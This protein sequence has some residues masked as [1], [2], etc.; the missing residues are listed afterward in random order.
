M[1]KAK[2]SRK[3]SLADAS[4]LCAKTDHSGWSGPLYRDDSSVIVSAEE[5]YA[6]LGP[7][8]P[9]RSAGRCEPCFP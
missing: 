6:E 2:N 8:L 9:E 4:I 5:N 3:I 1:L 7:K